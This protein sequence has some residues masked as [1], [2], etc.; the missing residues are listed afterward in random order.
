VFDVD[1]KEQ[2]HEKN[3]VWLKFLNKILFLYNKTEHC[4]TKKSPFRLFLNVPGFN[5]VRENPNNT[6]ENDETI[7]DENM[8]DNLNNSDLNS[9]IDPSYLKR[10][11]RH[12][13][14]HCFKY[15][16]DIGDKVMVAK[17]FDNNVKTK[18]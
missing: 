15:N 3:K 4:A 5:I 18:K 16:F 17:D 12:S 14:V 7:M 9:S 10:M 2:G 6:E 13:L 1:D 11:N 8:S